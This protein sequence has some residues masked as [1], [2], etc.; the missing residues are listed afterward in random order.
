MIYGGFDSWDLKAQKRRVKKQ[1][2]K[3]E[4]KAII[5]KS[6]QQQNDWLAQNPMVGL[7]YIL[8]VI[9]CLGFTIYMVG[10]A[11]FNSF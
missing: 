8:I 11:M 10:S 5:E 9:G 3:D 6:T 7:L 4:R 2:R 1:Q